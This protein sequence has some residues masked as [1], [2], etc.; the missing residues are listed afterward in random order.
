MLLWRCLPWTGNGTYRLQTSGKHTWDSVA[1]QHCLRAFPTVCS[2]YAPIASPWKMLLKTRA[3]VEGV[4][5][6]ALLHAPGRTHLGSAKFR[7]GMVRFEALVVLNF[8]QTPNAWLASVTL[9]RS[10]STVRPEPVEGLV[11]RSC[12]PDR[13]PSPQAVGECGRDEN[14]TSRHSPPTHDDCSL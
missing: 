14:P 10:L 12:K 4:D 9:P 5:I 2:R 13:P 1:I 6:F 8:D 3:S 7:I 11:R